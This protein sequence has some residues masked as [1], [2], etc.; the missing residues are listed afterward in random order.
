M[1]KVAVATLRR[2][3]GG[4]P[5]ISGLS[6]VKAVK[7]ISHWCV[8]PLFFVCIFAATASQAQGARQ[9]AEII[10]PD[11]SQQTYETWGFAPA[12]KIDGVIYVSGVIS[13]LQGDG[14]YEERYGRGFV[15][16]MKRIE[17]I[18]AEAGA[19]MDDIVEFTTFHT[20]LQRQLQT[21][22]KVRLENMNPPHPAWTAVGT[23]ALASP[24]G[25]TEIKVIAH[26]NE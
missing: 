21:A 24:D 18:L 1:R 23:T 25:M 13:V 26:V 16:A 10:V 4:H 20:D 22:V 17:S 12:V 3:C 6:G 2:P 14:S 7:R 9:D 15:S 19:S 5:Q 8:A 11:R